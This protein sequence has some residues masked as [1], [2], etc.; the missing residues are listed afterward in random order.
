M[1]NLYV[2]T[3]RKMIAAWLAKRDQMPEM[4]WLTGTRKFDG[5][6]KQIK[7]LI[8][9]HVQ[10]F[11]KLA[12]DMQILMK[13]LPSEDA[14]RLYN[15][16]WLSIAIHAYSIKALEL[17]IDA[18][19]AYDSH[20]FV[21]AFLRVDQAKK[22]MQL[23]H[24]QW[25]TNPEAKWRH[26]YDNDCYANITLAAEALATLENVIRITCDGPDEI[27]SRLEGNDPLL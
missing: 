18:I 3:L 1:M 20:D 19:D 5:Q 15:D 6:L 27:A 16:L 21:G 8:G 17:L 10:P 11:G 13:R 24:S 22:C 25:Q 4:Q 26:F 2:Y 12:T 14:G 23:I 7:K 9:P